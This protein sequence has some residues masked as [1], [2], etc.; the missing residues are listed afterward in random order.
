MT[1]IDVIHQQSKAFHADGD[2]IQGHMRNL[3]E[4]EEITDKISQS[5]P[6]LRPFL[7]YYRIR[8][9]QNAGTKLFEQS[10]DTFLLY[11]EEHQCLKALLELFT[12]TLHKNEASI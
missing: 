11:A 12:V 4:I 8:R 5:H 7:D 1:S 3:R 9:G 6:L 10:Q 2:I